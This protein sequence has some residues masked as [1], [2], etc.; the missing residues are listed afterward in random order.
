MIIRKV[1]WV[2]QFLGR[3]AW[4]LTGQRGKK[5]KKRS[6]EALGVV[7]DKRGRMMVGEVCGRTAKPCSGAERRSAR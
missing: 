2:G 1:G 7:S 6:P 5:K 3:V 4:K